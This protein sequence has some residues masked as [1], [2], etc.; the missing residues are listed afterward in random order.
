M[1]VTRFSTYRLDMV[2]L[3][4]LL[5]FCYTLGTR[6]TDDGDGDDEMTTNDD[7]VMRAEVVSAKEGF[8]DRKTDY[9]D[10]IIT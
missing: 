9:Y 3:F 5:L 4:K 8:K 2:N 1:I 6:W 10:K 7:V